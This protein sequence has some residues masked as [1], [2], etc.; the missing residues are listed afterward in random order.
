MPSVDRLKN[1]VQI[2]ASLMTRATDKQVEIGSFTVGDVPAGI[3]FSAVGTVGEHRFSLT[4]GTTTNAADLALESAIETLWA[5]V[6]IKEGWM[7]L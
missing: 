1:K 6:A 7:E 3:P 2:W 5:V 4:L